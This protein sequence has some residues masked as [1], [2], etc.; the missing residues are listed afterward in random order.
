MVERVAANGHSTIAEQ[1][2][3]I[4]WIVRPVS[5]VLPDDADAGNMGSNMIVHAWGANVAGAL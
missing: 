1:G 4:V 3:K 2:M 5:K